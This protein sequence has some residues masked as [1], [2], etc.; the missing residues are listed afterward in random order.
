M[1]NVRY[2]E[3][4]DVKDVLRLLTQILELHA[5]LRPDIF[6]SGTTKYKEEELSAIFAD[7]ARRSYVAVDDDGTV[8]GYALCVLKRQPFTNTMIPFTSLFVDDFCV[9][10]SARGRG[11]I[12]PDGRLNLRPRG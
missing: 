12:P 3:E 2:A 11:A 1:I 6:I 7:G 9:D 10:E 4:K 5:A 8:L